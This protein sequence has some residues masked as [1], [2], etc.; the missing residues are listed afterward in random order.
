MAG[1]IALEG[2]ELQDYLEGHMIPLEVR[3]TDHGVEVF[4]S[5]TWQYG[6]LTYCK[7]CQDCG[8]LPLDYDGIEYACHSTCR[9][10]D[11]RIEFTSN[12]WVD[13]D[14]MDDDAIWYETCP[15]NHEDRIAAHEPKE[16]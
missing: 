2:E 6:W 15:D 16:N 3:E 13:P 7:T 1:W 14:A 10:C 8:L 5:H 11:R 12:G 9:H 4:D